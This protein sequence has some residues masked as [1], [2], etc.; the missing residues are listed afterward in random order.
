[1]HAV[2][3][4]GALLRASRKAV[5]PV[6]D[7]NVRETRRLEGANERCFQQ[8]ASDSTG[9][10]IIGH[11]FTLLFPFQGC[12][13]PASRFILGIAI[14]EDEYV[15]DFTGFVNELS[16][17]DRV[18]G[19]TIQVLNGPNA[20]RSTTTNSNGAYAFAGLTSGK[21]QSFCERYGLRRGGPRNLHQRLEH[22]EL[23]LDGSNALNF[24]FLGQLDIVDGNS[25]ASRLTHPRNP[26]ILGLPCATR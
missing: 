6:G 2:A 7:C 11:F 22:H 15:N 25:P 8:S 4:R 16:G 17:G 24:T 18:A 12:Q 9:P 1:V 13:T 19:V 10:G 3:A 26:F 23:R 5:E 14:D 20:G 21:R